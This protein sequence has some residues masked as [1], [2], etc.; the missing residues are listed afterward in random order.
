VVLW[1]AQTTTGTLSQTYYTEAVQNAVTE[2]TYLVR[3]DG[4]SAQFAY[5][6]STTG[7]F[8]DNETYEGYSAT[9]TWSRGEAWGIYGFTMCAQDTDPTGQTDQYGFIATAE[10]MANYFIANLPSD[11]VPYW[12]FNAPDIPSTYRDSSAAAVAAS[13]LLNLSKLIASTDPTDS[14]KYRSAAASILAS[15]ASPAYMNSATT[16]ANGLL[17]QGALN[18][19]P[20]PPVGPDS[21]IIFGDYYFLEAVNSYIAG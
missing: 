12:D 2:K 4:G 13:G 18:V 3:A 9:S 14:A 11:N 15:L 21:S 20:N 16:A 7:N 19:P 6:N 5:F 10:K 1:A 17:L 8:I